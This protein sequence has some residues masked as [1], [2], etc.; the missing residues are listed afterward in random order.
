MAVSEVLFTPTTR[1]GGQLRE[2]Q[3][4]TCVH[5]PLFQSDC[6][7]SPELESF[8]KEVR[9]T[10]ESANREYGRDVMHN[11]SREVRRPVQ[12]YKFGIGFSI[13][14]HQLVQV[15]VQK[16]GVPSSIGIAAT[17]VG[18]THLCQTSRSL[19]VAGFMKMAAHVHRCRL[20]RRFLDLLVH[21]HYQN[22]S[23]AH[24]DLA[25]VASAEDNRAVMR[26]RFCVR[27]EW[28]HACTQALAEAFPAHQ[29]PPF[30]VMSSRNMDPSVGRYWPVRA[31]ALHCRFCPSLK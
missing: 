30:A 31:A 10:L 6:M 16:A 29:V 5:R 14:M 28:S 7:T 15:A 22:L 20:T 17:E 26:V 11:F 4:L 13:H 12:R 3:W 9:H 8:R 27:D 25:T 2:W 19:M 18:L 24:S 23:C 1:T 21:G